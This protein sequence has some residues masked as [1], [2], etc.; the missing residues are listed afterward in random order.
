MSF[1]FSMAEE[2]IGSLEKVKEREREKRRNSLIYILIDCELKC[3]EMR[4][5][6]MGNF[7]SSVVE[8]SLS[9]FY[10]QGSMNLPDD[11]VMLWC[12][13][14]KELSFA[15]WYGDMN[16]SL[17]YLYEASVAC[18]WV[19]AASPA[20]SNLYAYLLPKFWPK[21]SRNFKNYGRKCIRKTTYHVLWSLYFYRSNI[22]NEM[23]AGKN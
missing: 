8:K 21:K 2:E 9:F 6:M 16:K 18:G 20:K 14:I 3:L 22:W 13:D 5:E 17:W 11:D 1:F 23:R 7:H 12:G 10:F 15:P 4:R 19:A